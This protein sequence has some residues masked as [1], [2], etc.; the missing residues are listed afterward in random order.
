MK[1]LGGHKVNRKPVPSTARLAPSVASFGV[2]FHIG[3]LR[4]NA[5]LPQL[6]QPSIF[7]DLTPEELSL[8]F[9]DAPEEA[10]GAIPAYEATAPSAE[11]AAKIQQNVAHMNELRAEEPIF[12]KILLS[13][14][15]P[16]PAAY[17]M[18][19]RVKSRGFGRSRALNACKPNFCVPNAGSINTATCPHTGRSFGTKRSASSRSMTS[20]GLWPTPPSD[21]ATMVNGVPR[22]TREGPSHWWIRTGF[23]P[24][25]LRSAG[26]RLPQLLQA[27]I[28]PGSVKS[29]K[30]GYTLG[31]LQY[32]RQQRSQG[33]GSAYNFVLVLQRMADPFFAGAVPDIYANFLAITRFYENLQITIERGEAH[34]LDVALPE[35]GVNMPLVVNVPSYLR[36]TISQNLTLDGNFKANLFFKRDDGSDT[37]LTDGKMYF[38]NQTEFEGIAKTYVVPDKDK[39]VPCKAHIGSIRH[40]GQVKYGNTAVSGVVA[41][42][43]DH[44]VLGSLVD[45]L[46]GEA[47][48]LGT[49]AQR[50]QLRHT[51][52]PPHGPETATPIV[53]S[54]D[55]WCSFVVHQVERAI[56]LFPEEEWL[57]TL[58]ASTIW[59]A[60]YFACRGHFHGETAE[61]LWAFLNPLGSSTRQ[62]TGAARHDIIN[63][64][65]HSWNILKVLSSSSY[66]AAELLAA[67]RLDALRLFELH[68]AVVEDLSRAACPRGWCLVAYVP[69]HY[70]SLV[71]TIEN[72]LA[73][74]IATEQEK[75]RCNDEHEAGTP[76]AQWIHD[77][78]SIEREQERQREIYPRLKL[79]A[80]DVDEPELTAIQLPSYHMK[81]GQRPTSGG[82]ASDQDSQLRDSEIKLRCTEADSGILAVRAASL[83]LSAVKKARDLDYRGQAGIT[84][85]QRNLQKAELMKSFE[86]TMYNNA[87]AA[88]INLGHM[89]KDA[90]EPYRPLS[91]RDTRR[92]ETH[93]HRAKGD[94]RLFDGTAWYLQSGVTISRAA[95]ASTLST[96]KGEQENEDNEPQLL[97]GTQTLKRSGMAPPPKKSPTN[98]ELYLGGFK[99]S[100][101][102][103]K[104][105]KDIAP[106]NVEVESA[107]SSDAEDGALE[108]SLSRRETRKAGKERAKKGNSKKADG[109]IWLESLTRGQA[110]SDEKLAAYKKESDRVQWFRAEAEMYRWLEQ[111]ERKHAELMRVIERYRR[112]SVVWTG[113]ADREEKGNGGIN[114]VVNFARMQAAMHRRLE[115]NA[116]VIFKSVESGAHHDWVSATSFDELVTKIDGWRGVVFKWM[117]EMWAM[118]LESDRPGLKWL[119]SMGS[120][121]D[122]GHIES[123][124]PTSSEQRKTQIWNT[125]A[126][127]AMS[128]NKDTGLVLVKSRGDGGPADTPRDATEDFHPAKSFSPPLFN[129]SP[130]AAPVA[131]VSECNAGPGPS[132]VAARNGILKRQTV[133]ELCWLQPG[134]V[135]LNA[136]F[137]LRSECKIQANHL[138]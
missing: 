112:D 29:P 137:F 132:D 30:T 77:G 20:V 110:L 12:L 86:I 83:A 135:R 87:R 18:S 60:V 41:S 71:M 96:G 120:H 45:M 46:K 97:A 53:F 48:A 19:L 1:R 54:Y 108:I 25:A 55:S 21:S 37:A 104:R 130:T 105:M 64:V 27:G 23:T 126:V 39:E 28:F 51:N 70:E 78:M 122:M 67:E 123:H 43:C 38:P 10:P 116:K 57:H 88:L 7:D 74:M 61:T 79:S 127:T 24:P 50:E 66:L 8:P 72:M 92:K 73:T 113:L 26:A 125:V 32:H 94:S 84:R 117:D 75:S 16:H 11:K 100:Q 4:S 9:L 131:T 119:G 128:G 44:A 22:R 52:S 99:H 93:L 56:T 6:P 59:Q 102:S 85:S 91:S 68:M 58:L 89:E 13:L 80:L 129:A 107:V 14:H 33:K 81:H 95:V 63:F 40:Q 90:V 98:T 47:F 69:N 15:H 49:F 106:D 2:T 138:I 118:G 5:Q 65:M 109:W 34:G 124:T 121:T 35:R 17:S 133:L 115:H 42:A 103:P 36:H 31:L 111:Y 3:A 82:D 76:V 101:R 114:G 136:L 62:M 134:M